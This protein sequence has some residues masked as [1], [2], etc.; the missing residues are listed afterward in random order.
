MQ[1]SLTCLCAGPVATDPLPAHSRTMVTIACT[2]GVPRNPLERLDLLDECLWV[3]PRVEPLVV[4]L[5]EFF[6]FWKRNP[7]IIDA[8][9]SGVVLLDNIGL[10]D[11]LSKMRRASF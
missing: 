8:M 1:L 5:E 3:A 4:S 2:E 6:K 9:Q 11:Y 7:A 10:K